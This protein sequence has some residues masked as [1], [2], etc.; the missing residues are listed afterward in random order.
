MASADVYT[1]KESRSRLV[2]CY[3]RQYVPATVQV[4]TKGIPVRGETTGWETRGNKWN[5]VRDAAVYIQTRTT[6]SEDHYT[7]VPKSCPRR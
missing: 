2:A 7:L 3:E 5:Q 1:V 6:I 4:D